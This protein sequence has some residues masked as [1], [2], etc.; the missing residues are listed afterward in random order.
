M[1]IPYAFLSNGDLREFQQGF[2]RAHLGAIL[3][4]IGV[5]GA[6]CYNSFDELVDKCIAGNRSNRSYIL[7]TPRLDSNAKRSLDRLRSVSDHEICVIIADRK[8]ER[9]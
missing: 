4:T 5:S 9:A 1:K 3:R 7:V 8:E 6:V 2:G